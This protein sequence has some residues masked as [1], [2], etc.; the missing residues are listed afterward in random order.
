[1]GAGAAGGVGAGATTA[2]AA[3]AGVVAGGVMLLAHAL[4]IFRV[5]KRIQK[6][7]EKF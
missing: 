1:V 2:G 3:G 7:D 4:P 6:Q 5:L